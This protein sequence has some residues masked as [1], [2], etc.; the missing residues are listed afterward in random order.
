MKLRKKLPLKNK[1]NVVLEGFRFDRGQK[2]TS[3]DPRVAGDYI[4][5]QHV[6][7]AYS[8]YNQGGSYWNERGINGIL[9]CQR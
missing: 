2:E 3:K 9:C 7:Y 4:G 5:N 8:D 1:N 6:N